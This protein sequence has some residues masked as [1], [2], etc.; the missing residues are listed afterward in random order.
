MSD[1]LAIEPHQ[2]NVDGYRCLELNHPAGGRLRVTLQGAQ[3]ISWQTASGDEQLYLS[4]KPTPDP[5]DPI[6]GGVPI[7]F[8]QFNQRVLGA[9][10]LPKH[11]FARTLNWKLKTHEAS[12]GLCRVTL[13]LNHDDL[14]PSLRSHWAH[15]FVATL[16]VS[17]APNQL[18]LQFSARNTGSDPWPFALALHTYLRVSDIANVQLNGLQGVQYWDAVRH[19]SDPGATQVQSANSLSFSAETDRVYKNPPHALTLK[20]TARTL[21]I[22]QSSQFTETVVWNPGQDLC[23]RLADMP[24]DG[25]RHMLCVE[26]AKIDEAVTLAAGQSWTGS[27]TLTVAVN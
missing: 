2:V 7:C 27:Q 22:E 19:L 8:P 13:E 16:K 17:L 18:Q 9:A 4:P 21:L 20:D 24:A 15:R 11:G 3:V 6:R 14:P 12:T 26:A 1:L 10:K 5:G 25:Y 23:T